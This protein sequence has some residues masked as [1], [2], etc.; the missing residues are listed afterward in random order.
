MKK[1]ILI[2]M[3]FV[4]CIIM[5]LMVTIERTI[6]NNTPRD[7][8]HTSSEGANAAA[9]SANPDKSN[10]DSA[11]PDASSFFDG[12]FSAIGAFFSNPAAPDVDGG[13]GAAEPQPEYLKYNI[14]GTNISGLEFS[15]LFQANSEQTYQYFKS[16]DL[17][18]VRLPFSWDELQP[19]LYGDFDSTAKQFLD[20]NIAWAKTHGLAVILDAHNYGRHSVYRN[21]GFHDDFANSSQHTFIVPYAD[22]DSANASLTF[23]DYGRGLAGTAAN[24]ASPAGSYSVSLD[25]R[26]NSTDGNIWDE[27]FLDTFYQDEN[28]RYTLVINHRMSHW[29][30]RK[31]VNGVSTTLAS[32]NKTWNLGQYYTFAIDINQATPGKIN[33]SIDGVPLFTVNS[34]ASDPALTAGYVSVFPSGVNATV[35]AFTLDVAGDASSGGPLEQRLTDPNLPLSAWEDFWKKLSNAYKNEPTV[36]AYDHNEPHDMPVPTTPNNYATQVAQAHGQSV[37]T[38]TTIGQAM[39]NAVRSTGDTKYVVVDMDHWANTHYF[40]QQYGTNPS[41]WITDIL[42]QKVVYSGHYYFDSDHSGTY[43]GSSPPPAASVT[44]EVTPFFDWCKTKQVPCYIGEFGVPNTSEWQPIMT[45]FLSLMKQHNIWWTQWAGGDLYSSVTTIQP[46]NSFT[47]DRL[48]MTTIRH[49][50]TQ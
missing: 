17:N 22:H 13:R 28:N 48:Q 19:Y 23:R 12:A 45:H 1:K 36:F 27:L 31:I 39:V 8:P 3:I 9:D 49:F 25:A 35:K 5:L 42:P 6:E 11:K 24:P 37:A 10:D 41:P 43:A 50:L 29:E 33:I 16:K 46:T 2:G 38:A 40:E 7:L 47:A 26:I 14:K 18:T 34:I 20:Q 21:G 15:G 44:D 30:L 32:G 4:V